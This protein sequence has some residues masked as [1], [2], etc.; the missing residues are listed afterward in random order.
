MKPVHAPA[1]ARR[2]ALHVL[3]ECRKKDAFVQEI[4][5]RHLSR[6]RLS[7]NDRA[8]TTQLAYG[9][10]RRRLT[11]DG[12]LRPLV[13]RPPHQVEPWLWDA[14]R[15]GAYQLLLLTQIPA[16]AALNETVELAT[17][18]GQPRAKG[19]LNGVLRS[20]LALV[21][22]DFVDS[23]AADAL[24]LEQGRFRRLRQAVLPSPTDY[25]VEYLTTA[26]ALPRWLVER[27]HQ[28]FGW[29]QCLDLGFWFA[30][31]APLWLRINPLK[32]DRPTFLAALAETGIVAEPGPHPQSV[33][34]A[35]S[36]PI[37]EVPH[38]ADGWCTVQDVSAMS[39]ASALA[40]QPGNRVLD[41]CAA[42]GAR[43]ATWWN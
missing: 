24:P 14:L 36:L 29:Q 30:S 42:P 7:A 23:P 43:L 16:Y 28:R 13:N 37:R 41:L 39:V 31:P 3:L 35:Q 8:L 27:W 18:Q 25:P 1:T 32:V 11:L 15:L 20:L 34:L 17:L 19:F 12:L 40:P 2:T 5:D 33:R 22:P 26:F 9:V 10:L 38:F 4:L 21:T 6:S